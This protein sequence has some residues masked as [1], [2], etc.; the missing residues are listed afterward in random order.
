[1]TLIEKTEFRLSELDAWFK[2]NKSAKGTSE[3][4]DNIELGID[5]YEIINNL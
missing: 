3:W 1:M 2:D 5:L 4:N